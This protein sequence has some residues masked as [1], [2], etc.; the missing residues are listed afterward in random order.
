MNFFF[1]ILVMMAMAAVLALGIVKAVLGS[2]WFLV[3]GL[4]VFFGLFVKY[5]CSSH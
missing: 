1:A 5:G 2:A 4:L 3:I